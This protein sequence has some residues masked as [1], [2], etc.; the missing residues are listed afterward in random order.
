M[1]ISDA[2]KLPPLDEVKIRQELPVSQ[3]ALRA[4]AFHL[5]KYCEFQSKVYTKIKAETKLGQALS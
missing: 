4:G 5:G 3:P 1:V 2:I